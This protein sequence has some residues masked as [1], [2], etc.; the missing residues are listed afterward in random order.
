[1]SVT[2]QKYND[3][4]KKKTLKYRMERDYSVCQASVGHALCIY[5]YG[6]VIV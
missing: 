1:M 5:S 6:I 2:T 4:S 3:Y